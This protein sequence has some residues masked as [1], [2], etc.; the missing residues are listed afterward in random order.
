MGAYGSSRMA[1]PAYAGMLKAASAPEQEALQRQR[2]Q[3]LGANVAD[4]FHGTAER[5][6]EHQ[7]L[8]G[9]RFADRSRTKVHVHYTEFLDYGMYETMNGVQ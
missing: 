9:K 1:S 7:M 4:W 8:Q 3:L 5:A 2:G 6:S